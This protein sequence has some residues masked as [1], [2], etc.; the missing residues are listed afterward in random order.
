MVQDKLCTREDQFCP[1]LPQW[2]HTY[3]QPHMHAHP[4]T[5]T[6]LPYTRSQFLMHVHNHHTHTHTHTHTPPYAPTPPPKYICTQTHA[7]MPICTHT[8]MHTHN[9]I[10]IATH[11]ITLSGPSVPTESLKV[12]V[13]PCVLQHVGNYYHSMTLFSLFLYHGLD[14]ENVLTVA[15]LLAS[16]YITTKLLN[17]F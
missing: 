11:P 1:Y 4:Y 16:A 5:C 13:V 15:V 17:E 6:Q 2:V 12:K 9:S 3:T 7:H 10:C 8:P 14:K